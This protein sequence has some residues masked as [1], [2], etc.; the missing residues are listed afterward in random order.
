MR[1]QHSTFEPALLACVGALLSQAF[2]CAGVQTGDGNGPGCSFRTIP[3]AN[4]TSLPEGFA[5]TPEQM[6]SPLAQGVTG[7]LT[8]ESG[9]RVPVTMQ[10]EVA[11]EDGLAVYR[12]DS[13]TRQDCDAQG[14]EVSAIATVDGGNVIHGETDATIRVLAGQIRVRMNGGTLETSL[15]RSTAEPQL[16]TILMPMQL[17]LACQ[18]SGAWKW[19]VPSSCSVEQ[20]SCDGASHSDEPIGQF[21]ASGECGR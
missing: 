15:E 19:G 16:Q 12:E 14:V 7:E 11:A 8:L 6:L 13:P 21:V 1:N 9:D 20:E 18:W 4:L 17:D 3:L 10:F 2:G 5:E